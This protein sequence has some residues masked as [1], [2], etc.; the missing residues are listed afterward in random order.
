MSVSAKPEAGA[1]LQS[2][3]RP[4]LLRRL[5]LIDSV[6]LV[7][8]GIMGSAIFLTAKDVAQQVSNPAIFLGLWLAGGVISL[9]ACFAVAELGTMYP[10]AGGQ[11]VFIREAYGDIFAFLYGWSQFTV[12]NTGGIAA[13]VVGFAYYL[14][15]IVPALGPDRVLH[16]FALGQTHWTFTAEHAV[17]LAALVF[18]TW[19]NVIGVKRA[20][21]LQ[22]IATFAKYAAVITFIFFGFTIGKGSWSHFTVPN[23]FHWPPMSA[24]GISLIAIFWAYDGWVYLGWAS[25]EIENP[26]R[27][28]PRALIA[29][30]VIVAAAYLTMNAV[31]IYAMPMAQIAQEDT[32]AKAAASQLFFPAAGF[33]LSA[34]IALSALGATSPA[35]LGGARIY[36]AMAND[37]LFFRKMATVHPRWRT[38]VFSLLVQ[39]A[40]GAMLA[41]SGRYDQLFTFSMFAMVGG[42]AMAVFS[43]FILRRTQPDMPRPYRCTGYPWVPALYVLVAVAW[44][45]NAAVQRPWETLGGLGIILLGVPLYW[46]WKRH[47][48]K[49]GARSAE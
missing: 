28:I 4:G 26:Q 5:T 35:V 1:G 46:Y 11:Y 33:W 21:I 2:E 41:L 24:L 14:G 44:A 16:T 27:N 30:I 40:W 12:G 47:A 13:L 45:I 9:L 10:D 20:A 34:V 48:R 39:G 3:A 19:I 42:Y 31:Y 29:G 22:N 36:Y 32:V 25:G 43:V 8:G 15:A 38:P 6:V 37:G 49:T 7:V 17:A 23:S 18:V